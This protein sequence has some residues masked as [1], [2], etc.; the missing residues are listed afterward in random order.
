MARPERPVD[1]ADGP[2]QRF[3]ADLR[4]LRIEA[5]SPP[6]RDMAKQVHVS[7]ASLAAAAGGHR[8]PTWEVTKQYVRACDGPFD[9]WHERWLAARAEVAPPLS[10]ASTAPARSRS[11]LRHRA[12]LPAAVLV[13]VAAALF[14]W[15]VTR[16]AISAGPIAP[17]RRPNCL[18]PHQAKLGSERRR[19]SRL[20]Q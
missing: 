13:A 4:K 17:G 1:P 11:L 8:L 15:N 6:Y 19:N 10:A 12:F 2:A 9:I 5:G 7:K 14:T 16:S 20:G 3:A 18:V